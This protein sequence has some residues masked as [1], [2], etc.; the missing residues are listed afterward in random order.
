MLGC[1]S[2]SLQPPVW[3]QRSRLP[4]GSVKPQQRHASLADHRTYTTAAHVALHR[5][6]L[7]ASRIPSMGY[8][9]KSS[10]L[11]L[12][13]NGQIDPI[14]PATPIESHCF[15]RFPSKPFRNTLFRETPGGGVCDSLF[16]NRPACGPGNGRG[17]ADSFHR[18]RLEIVEGRR[19]SALPLLPPGVKCAL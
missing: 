4:S 6:L 3:T 14:S 5:R 16:S 8:P 13:S 15:T 1:T 10:I 9:R 17:R 18:L 19:E 12:S 11:P 7:A 2:S